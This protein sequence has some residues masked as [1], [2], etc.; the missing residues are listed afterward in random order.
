MTRYGSIWKSDEKRMG[1]HWEKAH[2]GLDWEWRNL[3]LA[4]DDMNQRLGEYGLSWVAEAG[5]V[6][7]ETGFVKTFGW[8]STG[9]QFAC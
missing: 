9:K 8:L 5:D 2:S 3:V 6:V 4:V 7:S 1:T